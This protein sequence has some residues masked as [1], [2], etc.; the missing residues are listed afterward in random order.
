MWFE[1]TCEQSTLLFMLIKKYHLRADSQSRR[2]NDTIPHAGHIKGETPGQHSHTW[3]KSQSAVCVMASL[4]LRS[5]SAWLPR[6]QLI[7]W[8]SLS[9]MLPTLMPPPGPFVPASPLFFNSVSHCPLY[10]SI[11]TGSW[12]QTLCHAFLSP[13]ISVS[14]FSI[15]EA[16]AWSWECDVSVTDI[17]N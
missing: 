9:Q 13:V 17:Y 5:P 8:L 3:S 4:P 11:C 6:V 10:L 2:R 7:V 1:S 14:S 15:T 12:Q 16:W